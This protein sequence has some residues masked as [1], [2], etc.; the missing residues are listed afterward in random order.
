VSLPNRT[1]NPSTDSRP[2]TAL[3]LIFIDFLADPEL[4]S[5]TAT[6]TYP[7]NAGLAAFSEGKQIRS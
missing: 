6:I 1:D 3:K 5:P 2:K 4:D 7:H